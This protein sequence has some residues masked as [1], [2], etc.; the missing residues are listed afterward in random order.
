[1]KEEG[2]GARREEG[3]KALERFLTNEWIH[4][5]CRIST[6]T[7]AQALPSSS[8]SFFGWIFFGIPL[9]P[10]S[11]PSAMFSARLL[12]LVG[13]LIL[14]PGA[15]AAC[16][17]NA[18][19]AGKKESA[20][21]KRCCFDD[22]I[23]ESGITWS[24][25]NCEAGGWVRPAAS[26]TIKK[27][28][29]M[30]ASTKCGHPVKTNGKFEVNCHG[31]IGVFSTSYSSCSAATSGGSTTSGGATTGAATNKTG[32]VSGAL[33][34]AAFSAPTFALVASVAV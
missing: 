28:G 15:F 13:L 23:F 34:L 18:T 3:Q 30:V 6:S 16:T 11:C 4:V 33:Q 14:A 9:T 17:G 25:T 22:L 1:V 26:C 12:M 20:E 19:R 5:C 31:A 7:L 21:G 27:D 29:K 2:G 8:S 24:G 32:T 10:L